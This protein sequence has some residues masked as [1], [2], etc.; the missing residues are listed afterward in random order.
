MPG[1]ELLRFIRGADLLLTNEYEFELLCSKTGLGAGDVLEHV[2]ARITT[3][4]GRGV[5]LQAP[6][7]GVRTVPAAR[8]DQHADPTGA[9]VTLTG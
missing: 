7:I 4:A 2:G 9:A 6:G 3:L 8:V 5:R 1:A